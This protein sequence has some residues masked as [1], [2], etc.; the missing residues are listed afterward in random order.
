MNSQYGLTNVTSSK[1]KQ[2]KSLETKLQALTGSLNS[3]T[4][5]YDKGT[6]EADNQTNINVQNITRVEGFNDYLTTIK[7]NND[8]IKKFDSDITENILKDSDI[9][10]LQKNY[11]YLFWSILAVSTVLVSMNIVKKS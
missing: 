7:Q 10:V 6:D 1:Q 8:E 2:L 3:L 5:K 4:E 9:V 11:S